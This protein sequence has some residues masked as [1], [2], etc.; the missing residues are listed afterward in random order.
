MAE[1]RQL[2][3]QIRR[4]ELARRSGGRPVVRYQLTVDV[5][6]VDGKRKQLRK[7][8]ANEQEARKALDEIRGDV[9]KGTYVH[10]TPL[11]VDKAIDDWLLSRHGIKVKSKSGYAGVLAPVRSELGHLPVQKLTRRDVDELIQRLRDGSV[12]RAKGKGTRRKWGPRSCNYMLVALSQVFKQLAKDGTVMRNIVEDVDRVPGKPKKFA[13]YTPAQVE[14]VLRT[15]RGDRNRHVWHLA[16]YG[17]RRGEIGGLRWTNVDFDARTL[18]IGPTRISVDGK[19]V[20]QDDA[21]SEDS[22]RTVPIPD[23]L[24]AELKAARKRQAEEQLALGTAYHDDGYVVCNEAGEPYHPDTLSKM[25][26][27]A[28]AA[29]GVPHIRLH[30]ARHTCGTTMPL[31][32]VPPAVIAAWLG[33]ADVSFTMRTYVHSQP[34]A[35]AEGAQTLARIVTIRDNVPGA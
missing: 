2:P 34:D 29:A 9:G 11:T 17:L 25:W 5:G 12:A 26:T 22:E 6:I 8:Y 7:R 27:K 33:H 23:P 28:V 18:T 31:Q 14:Q 35:L 1:R 13:T 21:K 30:D 16:L 4:V 19:A 3:P 24:R 15:I 20:E 32:G 10:A